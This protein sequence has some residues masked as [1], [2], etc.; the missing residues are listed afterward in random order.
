M[1]EAGFLR[2]RAKWP[3]AAAGLALAGVL[4]WGLGPG[5]VVGE[6]ARGRWEG[7]VWVIGVF[8][9]QQAL[10]T[11]AVWVLGTRRDGPGWAKTTLA[12]LARVRYIGE[13]LNYS[14]PTGGLGGEPYK[15]LALAP[16]EGGR[17]AFEAVAAAK[18]LHV[19]AVGP[20]T[21]V[22]FFASALSG[23]GG[24]GPKGSL[25]IIGIISV[26]VTLV[27]WALVL[28]RGLG[29]SLTVGFFRIRRRV[30]RAL[31][32]ARKLLSVDKAATA[33]MK[34]SG[35]R[36]LAAYGCYIGMWAAATV[37][38]YAIFKVVGTGGGGLGLAGAGLFECATIL[39]A[40]VVPMPAGLG[41]QEAGK[42]AVAVALGLPPETGLAMSLV[43]RAREA[44][45]ITAAVAAGAVELRSGK[46]RR[47]RE[48]DLRGP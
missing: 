17:A 22:V 16:G 5:D 35:A 36:T 3:I 15:Y 45:M 11:F 27:V 32:R 8:A 33:Q 26:A 47:E 23:V 12:R 25:V 40:G 19:A 28:W 38:W 13:V 20:F 29:R 46:G 41:T 24:P 44:V 18:F 10:G 48:E 9:L 6:L 4:V 43:R 14:M 37:E 2:G 7:F 42:T 34:R 1:R 21:A 30:P 31:W 39:V